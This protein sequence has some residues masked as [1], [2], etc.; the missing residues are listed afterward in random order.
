LL[1]GNEVIVAGNGTACVTLFQAGRVKRGQR[2][3]WNSGCAS[4]GYDLPAA[5]GACIASK[6]DTICITG[7]GSIMMNLQELQT[8]KNY[9]LPIKI[10]ILNNGGYKSI[11]Q[12]QNN[13][14]NGNYFGCNKDSGITFPDFKKI[15]KAFEIKYFKIDSASK[16]ETQLNKIL[17]YKKEAICEVFLSPDYIFQPKLA[18]FKKEDGTIESPSFENMFPFLDKE[19]LESNMIR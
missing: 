9:N 2:I 18:S 6:K 12:T 10:F 7:D 19:E 3:F 8:I 16:I 5:I 11:I 14:F 1:K 4:M 15:S 17:S 13:F